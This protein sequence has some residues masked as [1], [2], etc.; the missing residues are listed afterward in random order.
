MKTAKAALAA[1]MAACLGAALG[2]EPAPPPSRDAA[3]EAVAQARAEV[4]E[5]KAR[6]ASRRAEILEARSNLGREVSSLSSE[7]EELRKRVRG[8]ERELAQAR[9]RAQSLEEEASRLDET[10]GL[11]RSRLV[12]LL[13]D[14]ESRLDPLDAAAFSP[15]IGDLRASLEA[16]PAATRGAELAEAAAGILDLLVSRISEATEIRSEEG[17]ALGPDGREVRGTFLR[18]GAALALFASSG[19]PPLA[20]IVAPRRGRDGVRVQPAGG[21][22][23]AAAV[24]RAAGGEVA[25]VPVDV[26][27]GLALRAR[28]GPRAFLDAIRAGGPV[29]VPILAIAVLTAVVAVF[30]CAEL[31]R[32][33]VSFDRPVEEFLRLLSER[34]AEEAG[35]LARKARAPIR[36]LL[37]AA[38]ERRGRP[39]EDVEETLAEAALAEIPRLERGLSVLATGA[40]V[41]PLLGLLGTVTGMVHL[42][43]RIEVFGTGDARLLSGG[44]SEALVTTMAGLTVAI[45]LILVHAVLSRRVRAVADGLERSAL[46]LAEGC[47]A[48]CPGPPGGA[49]GGPA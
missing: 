12:E 26:T 14:A 48:G 44:I 28:E 30:K 20:G 11:L 49:E 35:A 10:L 38:F 27:S 45:P 19:D 9:A 47:A 15:R 23:A 3:A 13:R 31:L 1:S 7:V 40:V 37:A 25:L 8:A 32:T 33:P 29:M 41:E 21:A 22:S 34:R 43:G 4:A 42:F 36:G 46:Q 18:A 6:L 16:G 5:A 2:A 17:A 24:R 39:R